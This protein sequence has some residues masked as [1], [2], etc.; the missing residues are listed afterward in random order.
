M[1]SSATINPNSYLFAMELD[2]Y[3]QIIM[4]VFAIELKRT[5]DFFE[6]LTWKIVFVPFLSSGHC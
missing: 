6:F 5:L 4:N 3:L 1:L 2:G